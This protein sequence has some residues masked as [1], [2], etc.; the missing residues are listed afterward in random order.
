MASGRATSKLRKHGTRASAMTWH[1]PMSGQGAR[2]G[3]ELAAYGLETERALAF[4]GLNIRNRS[5][6]LG[7]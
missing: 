6:R 3:R 5:E 7:C 2:R 4:G 1:G